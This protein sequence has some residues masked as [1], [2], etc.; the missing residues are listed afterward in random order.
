MATLCEKLG[1]KQEAESHRRAARALTAPAAPPE[2]VQVRLNKAHWKVQG[3]NK[4]VET[5]VSKRD[6]LQ[7]QLNE[8]KTWVID[9]RKELIEAEEEHKALVH[10]LVQEQSVPPAADAAPRCKLSLEDSVS[11]RS[12]ILW[13]ATYSNA[14]AWASMK[15]TISKSSESRVQQFQ[16]GLSTMAGSLFS[17]AKQKMDELKAAHQAHVKRLA[18][19]RRRTDEDATDTGA[20]GGAPSGPDAGKGLHSAGPHGP[21]A[22]KGPQALASPGASAAAGEGAGGTGAASAPSAPSVARARAD[23]VAGVQ[24]SP[25]QVPPGGAD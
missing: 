20:E 6:A 24:A 22:G 7:S 4:R 18:A 3:I 5:A 14:R 19:K 16:K 25:D 8:Q 23:C 13:F 12:S 11:P 2:S 1:N 10:C 17:E 21:V 15:R 9:L